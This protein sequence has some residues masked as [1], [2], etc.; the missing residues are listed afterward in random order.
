MPEI[1]SFIMNN[2]FEE[3]KPM[4]SLIKFILSIIPKNKSIHDFT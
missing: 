2:G 1:E 3:I 4:G